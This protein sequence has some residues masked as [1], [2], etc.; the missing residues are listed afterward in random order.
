[1]NLGRR[2]ERQ[3]RI[4]SN[5]IFIIFQIRSIYILCMNVNPKKLLPIITIYIMTVNKN[6][7]LSLFIQGKI[8]A[9]NR[10]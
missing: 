10:V 6:A 5:H 9:H 7:F 2:N 1:M 8:T 4:I 3:K